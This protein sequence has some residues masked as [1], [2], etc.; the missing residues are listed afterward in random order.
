MKV[1]RVGH[2]IGNGDMVMLFDEKPRKGFKVACNVTPIQ[3]NIYAT[4]M[5]DFKFMNAMKSGTVAVPGN[6]VC[7]YRPKIWCEKPENSRYYLKW[8]SQIKEFYVDL[9]KYALMAGDGVGQGYTNWNCGHMATH[10]AIKKLKLDEVHMFGFDSIFD[11]NLKSYS[12]FILNS[13]R[14]AM[15]T[16]RLANNWRPI[17][18]HLFREFPHVKFVLHHFHDAFKISVPDNVQVEI[19]K[20]RVKPIIQKKNAVI[21][22]KVSDA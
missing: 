2:I 11:F 21:N 12:D 8:S 22:M 20:K 4:A 6:W 1:K 3:T 7:G 13:D 16:N 5:V 9:P 10:W 19:Y 18:E 17:W 15:N 14:E